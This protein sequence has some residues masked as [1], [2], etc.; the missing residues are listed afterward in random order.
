MK[1]SRSLGRG[2]AQVGYYD[3]YPPWGY[4]WCKSGPDLSS[5]L[6]DRNTPPAADGDHHL[7]GGHPHPP[8]LAARQVGDHSAVRAG[9]Q[10]IDALAAADGCG[11]SV[12]IDAVD[13]TRRH[14][15]VHDRAAPAHDTREDESSSCSPPGR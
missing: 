6:S 3:V 7:T 1:T 9:V 14:F 13:H 12:E 15:T 11:D 5:Q 2:F 8:H 10:V 4:H